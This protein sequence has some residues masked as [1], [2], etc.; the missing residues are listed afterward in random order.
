M[1]CQPIWWHQDGC[2]SVKHV[3][4]PTSSKTTGGT[5][6]C[7]CRLSIEIPSTVTC[8]VFSSLGNNGRLLKWKWPKTQNKNKQYIETLNIIRI[9]NT[10]LSEQC[11]IG[12]RQFGKVSSSPAFH[13]AGYR[14]VQRS[15]PQYINWIHWRTLLQVLGFDEQKFPVQP[16]TLQREKLNMTRPK[17]FVGTELPQKTRWW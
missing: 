2:Q 8:N 7:A 4:H 17:C 9:G 12:K 16:L 6:S 11:E 13:C 10:C 15:L 1:C 14:R 3:K 5:G